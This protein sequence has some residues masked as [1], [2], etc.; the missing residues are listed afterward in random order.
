M[1]DQDFNL[2]AFLKS[3]YPTIPITIVLKVMNKYD[4]DQDRCR[5]ALDEEKLRFPEVPESTAASGSNASISTN[6][7]ISPSE[8]KSVT[9]R[10]Q[11]LEVSHEGNSRQPAPGERHVSTFERS[12]MGT[13]RLPDSRRP[14]VGQSVSWTVQTPESQS[15][16]GITPRPPPGNTSV[17]QTAPA[18]FTPF[19]FNRSTTDIPQINCK[20]HTPFG[21]TTPKSQQMSIT[22]GNSS[23]ASSSP[24]EQRRPVK[25]INI[26][27]GS[28]SG[29]SVSPAATPPNSRH[30]RMHFGDT[31]GVCTVST[32][33][34]SMQRYGSTPNVSQHYRSEIRTE[35][36][37]AQPVHSS[38][39]VLNTT[40]HSNHYGAEKKL[41]NSSI[42][43]GSEHRTAHPNLNLNMSTGD[44]NQGAFFSS[45]KP[46]STPVQASS[47]GI[48]HSKPVFTEVKKDVIGGYGDVN[49]HNFFPGSTV[50]PPPPPSTV[51]SFVPLSNVT[52]N[53]HGT[54]NYTPQYVD[55]SNP[56]DYAGS[57]PS[58]SEPYSNNPMLMHPSYRNPPANPYL[59]SSSSGYDPKVYPP[60][61]STGLNFTTMPAAIV[62]HGTGPNHM[63]QY[64]NYNH[65][66]GGGLHHMPKSPNISGGAQSLLGSR[67]SSQ[68]SEHN[69]SYGMSPDFMDSRTGHYSSMGSRVSSQSSVGS[70]SSARL[71]RERMEQV[72]RPRSGSMQEEADY[73]RALLQH[74][75]LRKQKLKEETDHHT[76]VLKKLRSEVNELEKNKI[77]RGHVNKSF[78]S[79]EDIGVLCEKN[80]QLQTNIQLYMNEIDMYKSGQT[81]YNKID[82]L[83]QQNFFENMPKGQQDPIYSRTQDG[84]RTPSPRPTPPPRPPPPI[85]VRQRS[86]EISTP[87]SSGVTGAVS[88]SDVFNRVLPVP[89]AQ[90]TINSGDSEEGESWNCTACTFTNHPALQKCEMCEIPRVPPPHHPLSSLPPRLAPGIVGTVRARPG[91]PATAMGHQHHH[92]AVQ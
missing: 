65:H 51:S 87:L 36:S 85:P 38:S 73:T 53:P 35:A 1:A 20:T 67:S 22:A 26:P 12:V 37:A 90:P 8:I 14:V 82:P 10:V 86:N 31:G 84:Q 16:Q 4:N 43:C 66:P 7:M 52:F 42:D 27:P 34:S 41:S 63:P 48:S 88:N 23:S 24:G 83:G 57:Q 46:L 25:V 78:P 30:I 56:S 61:G 58:Q 69:V 39:I 21:N 68:D 9:S 18:D 3:H 60:M 29:G 32:P 79:V 13:P 11:E 2:L 28:L 81:P 80:R 50:R 55:Y 64:P 54:V 77:D 92:R 17:P 33:P 40:S 15:S 76:A 5:Q 71:E 19:I 6:N 49:F 44:S 70:D 47:P 91:S 59:P 72:T 74:Q 45:G 89:P 62:G 75:K